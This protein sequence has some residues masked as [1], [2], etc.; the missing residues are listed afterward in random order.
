MNDFIGATI[1]KFSG[2]LRHST[3]KAV[4]IYHYHRDS[5]F[6]GGLP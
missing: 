3:T 6:Y 4:V 2:T 5:M 1:S